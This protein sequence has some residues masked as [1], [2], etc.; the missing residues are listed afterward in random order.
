[1]HTASAAAEDACS[2]KR[3]KYACLEQPYYFVPV[4][5]ETLGSWS[6]AAKDFVA[7]LGRKLGEGTGDSRSRS[8][9]VQRLAIAIQRGNAASVMGTFA[10]GTIRGGLFCDL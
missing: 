4:A 10:P 3:I 8:F 5:V 7:E 9:L 6:R 1:M 2:V